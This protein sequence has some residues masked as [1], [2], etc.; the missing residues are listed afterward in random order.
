MF[1]PDIPF[2]RDDANRFLPWMI[3]LM[4]G[5]AALMLCVG[6]TLGQW[7]AAQQGDISGRFSVQIP[8][9]GD[10][11]PARVQQAARELQQYT[12]IRSVRTLSVQE[13]QTLVAPWLGDNALVKS[14]PMPTL[15]EA[16]L[17]NPAATGFDYKTLEQ[18]LEKIAPGAKVDSR[19]KWADTFSRFSRTL[20]VA[21]YLLAGCIVV[22]LAGMM[23]FTAR[24][25]MKLHASTVLLLHAIGAEDGYIARQFQHNALAL[26]LRGAVPGTLAA[27]L[28]YFLLGVYAARL[29]A[30]LLPAFGISHKHAIL[31][32]A[33]PLLSGLVTLI[34]VRLATL[35]QLKV[36]P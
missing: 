22:A 10:D 16:T 31:L 21:V 7:A 27:A 26:A 35:A 25:A 15:L 3:A 13:V 12:G 23:V 24:A 17:A 34:A 18:R 36:L 1:R 5:I 28:L 4:S 30:P 29:D 14:L 20:Q 6:L 11:T 8:D 32:I 2:A 33:L 19:E 9:Q